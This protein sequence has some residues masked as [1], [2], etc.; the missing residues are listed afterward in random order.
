[1]E[2][3]VK[4]DGL[5]EAMRSMLA[6]FPSNRKEQKIILNGAMRK[7]ASQTIAREAKERA[8]AGDS[9]GA[10]SEAIGIRARSRRNI[11][12]ARTVGA[13]EVTPIRSNRKAMLM[14][15]QHYYTSR[16]RTAPAGMIL[17]GIRHGH[18]IEFGTVN[19]GPRPFLWPAA[20]GQLSP[21]MARLAAD[22]R[23]Q[24]E[25]RVRRARHG[26]HSVTGRAGR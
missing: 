1:V 3:S 26:K 2:A 7:S 21:Y 17:S 8:L 22:M 25:S 16:G 13:L 18:L 5:E 20:K 4:I 6:A 19:H 24:I 15:I 9:S 12:T 10:L 14:Y 11:K 23:R